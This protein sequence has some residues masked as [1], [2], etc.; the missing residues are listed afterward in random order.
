MEKIFRGPLPLVLILLIAL[1]LRLSGLQWGL[2]NA[3]HINT[4]HPDELTVV[5]RSVRSI[6]S[7]NGQFL[8]GFYRYGSLQLYLINFACTAAFLV[9]TVDLIPA[10]LAST[11]TAN[12]DKLYLI[13][14]CLTVLMGVGT[15]WT[16]AAIGTRLWNRKVG[17]LA[18]LL[19]AVAPLHVL[20]SH[21]AT[22]DVPATFWGTM[23]V[24]AAIWS[25]QPRSRLKGCLLSG[26][27]TGLASATKYN[28]A[29]F[30]LP[31][32]AVSILSAWK[33]PGFFA[34][35]GT[36]DVEDPH[37]GPAKAWTSSA[38]AIG[39]GLIVCIASF[40]AACPGFLLQHGQFAADFNAEALHV[41]KQ[42]GE[43][44][45]Y[46]GN[47]FVYEW[48]HTL[49]AGLGPAL[50]L[51]VVIGIVLA[52]WKRDRSSIVIAAAALPYSILI[53]LAAVRYARY[54]IPLL[55]LLMLWAAFWI[56]SL[57]GS[58]SYS[59]EDDK[60][61]Q[62]PA[63]GLRYSVLAASLVAFGLTLGY[64]LWLIVPLSAPDPRDR[65]VQWLNMHTAPSTAIAFP[66]MPWFQ[67]APV[68][69]YLPSQR[70]EWQQDPAMLSQCSRV[71]YTYDWDLA[72]LSEGP[73]AV[74]VSEY[75]TMDALRVGNPSA[76][77]YMSALK[78][79]YSIGFQDGGY[80]PPLGFF[81]RHLPHDM[82]Y[83]YPQITVYVRR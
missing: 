69:L 80:S 10:H 77:T 82:I 64:T 32:V 5:E 43:S 39:C 8:P 51:F 42:P 19:L 38:I 12:W 81:M 1:S 13:A 22:V 37:Q 48:L 3:L 50:L 26:L 7:L 53:G 4:Y 36:R 29:L 23:A 35:P 33:G 20:Q 79:Q 72:P 59:P 30:I 71:L 56:V 78:S 76:V 17:L 62:G 67:T 2:P 75:D 83:A 66:T 55:P 28:M 61:N 6:N 16:T 70:G 54:A 25:L 11:N 58:R 52:I 9:N 18:G 14:R 27:F 60:S 40:L 47:G 74:V 24:L 44:F 31:M 65:A 34:V 49:V 63:K 45:E 41:S 73:A 21:W 46:T 68:C 15:V 57:L